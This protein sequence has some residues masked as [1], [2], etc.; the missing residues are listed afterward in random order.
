MKGYLYI[1]LR[2]VY[3]QKLFHE[4]AWNEQK[5]WEIDLN[6]QGWSIRFIMR[7]WILL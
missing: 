6:L 5:K 4:H 1:L 2:Q 3:M 7:Q